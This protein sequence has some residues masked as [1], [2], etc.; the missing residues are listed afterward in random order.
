M[1]AIIH[2]ES[3]FV[4]NARPD[5]KWFLFIPLPRQSSAFGYAQAQDPAWHEYRLAT[6]SLG[7]DRDSFEDAIDF[8]GWYTDVTQKRLGTSKWDAY[9]QYLAYHEG[10]TGYQRGAWKKKPWL[11]SVANKVKHRAATYG[12]QLKRCKNELD[13]EIDGWF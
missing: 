9:T 13:D 4:H 6:R 11:K 3:R 1:M 5:R 2:Q 7:A 12:G 10:R 8:V